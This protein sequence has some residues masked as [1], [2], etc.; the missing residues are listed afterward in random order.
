MFPI[1]ATL[2]LKNFGIEEANFTSFFLFKKQT[3]FVFL[4]VIGVTGTDTAYLQDT[5]LADGGGQGGRSLLQNGGLFPGDTQRASARPAATRPDDVALAQ[6]QGTSKEGSL[7]TG[8]VQP[9]S[10]R[11]HGYTGMQELGGFNFHFRHVPMADRYV[12]TKFANF[13]GMHG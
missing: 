12:T 9:P 2:F 5:I 13:T 3:N 10:L 8:F 7:R 6:G 4:C 11:L 1:R